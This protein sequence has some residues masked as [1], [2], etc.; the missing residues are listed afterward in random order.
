MKVLDNLLKFPSGLKDERVVSFYKEMQQDIS[1]FENS[2]INV[3]RQEVKF[4]TQMNNCSF[5]KFLTN[6]REN[7]FITNLGD[8]GS[9][10]P[11]KEL[12]VFCDFSSEQPKDNIKI[13]LYLKMLKLELS[14][15][16][17]VILSTSSKL[18]IK[19]QSLIFFNETLNRDKKIGL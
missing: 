6:L 4:I 5:V 7:N 17:C 11:E 2:S 16:K 18:E 12:V 10:N 1:A 8:W 13:Y 9:N 15:N 19:D 14:N 3:V